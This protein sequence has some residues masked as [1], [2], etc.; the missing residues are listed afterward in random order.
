[1]MTEW[2]LWNY[3]DW[4]STLQSVEKYALAV[5]LLNAESKRVQPGA[6]ERKQQEGP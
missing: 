5:L 2:L 3:D 4:L 1:M 6:E